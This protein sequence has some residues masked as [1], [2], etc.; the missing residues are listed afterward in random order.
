MHG[1]RSKR[2]GRFL[3]LSHVGQRDDCTVLVNKAG[4][5]KKRLA[6]HS[7]PVF[8][9]P[10][11]IPLFFSLTSNQVTKDQTRLA[12]LK[13]EL[14]KLNGSNSSSSSTSTSSSSRAVE[15]LEGSSPESAALSE[16][17]G[18]GAAGAAHGGG[19]GGSLSGVSQADLQKQSALLNQKLLETCLRFRSFASRNFAS[20]Q[21]VCPMM[22]A[23][24]SG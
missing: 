4:T 14:Q 3:C 13:M 15:V 17:G 8:G 11:R 6:F 5:K 20:R 10:F 12:A 9:P 19:A 22:V 7:I 23:I 1:C 24:M 16:V 2:W 18:G 21:A